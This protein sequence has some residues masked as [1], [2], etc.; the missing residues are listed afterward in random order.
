MFTIASG[1]YFQP[2]GPKTYI[3]LVKLRKFKKTLSLRRSFLCR[4]LTTNI[5]CD[6]YCY[7]YNVKEPRLLFLYRT[8]LPPSLNQHPPHSSRSSCRAVWMLFMLGSAFWCWF[9]R[10]TL[11]LLTEAKF[12]LFRR[13]DYFSWVYFPL[14]YC[15]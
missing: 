2:L 8:Y 14:L 11:I 4:L 7:E 12:V 6:W 13:I 3:F 15:K 9:V 5:E 1:R 10:S